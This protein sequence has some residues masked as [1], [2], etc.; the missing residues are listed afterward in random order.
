M[1]A[2]IGNWLLVIGEL[3]QISTRYVTDVCRKYLPFLRQW[4]VTNVCFFCYKNN[5]AVTNIY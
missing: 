2:V 5:L 4:F 1:N 3:S